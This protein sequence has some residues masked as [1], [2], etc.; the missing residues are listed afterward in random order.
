MKKLTV[1]PGD[2]IGPEVMNSVIE[3]LQSVQAPFEYDF[4]TGDILSSANLAKIETS[5]SM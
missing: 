2:G 4:T 5:P 3:V 1:I